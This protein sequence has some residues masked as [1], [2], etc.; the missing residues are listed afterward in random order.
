MLTRRPDIS[1]HR[2]PGLETT[3]VSCVSSVTRRA[4]RGRTG[5]ERTA[6][7][8]RN[9]DGGACLERLQLGVTWCRSVKRKAVIVFTSAVKLP[10]RPASDASSGHRRSCRCYL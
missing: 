5:G 3:S 6:K 2:R 10:D 8:E 7:S 9:K 1:L 4:E